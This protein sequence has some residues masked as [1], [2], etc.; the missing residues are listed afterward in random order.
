LG[1]SI[2]RRI[3]GCGK[4]TTKA[5]IGPLRH[6]RCRYWDTYTAQH[7]LS[8]RRVY[9]H[10]VSNTCAACRRCILEALYSDRPRSSRYTSRI[11]CGR[12]WVPRRTTD[13][14][15]IH[16]HMDVCGFHSMRGSCTIK[17]LKTPHTGVP[18]PTNQTSHPAPM[19]EGSN[20]RGNDARSEL[21]PGGMN[22]VPPKRGLI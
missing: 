14:D 7:A 15:C 16:A 8:H 2:R 4:E 18:D 17:A 1:R 6:P 19:A 11:Q 9:T 3:D 5:G 12:S 20:E 10:G 13:V 22:A 21:T